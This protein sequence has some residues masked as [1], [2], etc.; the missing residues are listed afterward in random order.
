MY[1]LLRY[2]YYKLNR[3]HFLYSIPIIICVYFI[4]Y[5]VANSVRRVMIAETVIQYFEMHAFIVLFLKNDYD[6]INKL[7]THLVGN[8]GHRLGPV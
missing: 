2:M 6:Y 5:S 3:M 4:A 7:V 1:A 8:N